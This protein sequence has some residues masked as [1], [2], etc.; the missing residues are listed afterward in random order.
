M[1]GVMAGALLLIGAFFALVV[2]LDRWRAAVKTVDEFE[3]AC[4]A[5]GQTTEHR[6]GCPNR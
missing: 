4:W 1:I 3:G 6:W 5:C 2:V